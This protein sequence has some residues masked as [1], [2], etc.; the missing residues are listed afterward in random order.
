MA[1]AHAFSSIKTGMTQD[2]NLELLKK[3]V[4]ANGFAA[5]ITTLEDGSIRAVVQTEGPLTSEG[6]K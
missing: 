1:T 3:I 4:V 2:E 5:S 6:A